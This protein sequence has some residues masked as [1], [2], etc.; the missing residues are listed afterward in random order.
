MAGILPRDAYHAER[1]YWYDNPKQRNAGELTTREVM[2][3]LDLGY[4][5]VLD[6]ARAGTLGKAVKRR[7]Q[8]FFREKDIA[9]V[10][11]AESMK[12]K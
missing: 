8:W 4:C 10:A 12:K 9:N 1:L 7:N 3:A 6:R 2:A 11:L 5:A